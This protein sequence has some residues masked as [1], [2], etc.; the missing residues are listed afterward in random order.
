[1]G[2]FNLLVS[3]FGALVLFVPKK[4][5]GFKMCVDYRALNK[6]TSQNRCPLPHIDELLDRLGVAKFFTKIDLRSGYHQ[7]RVHPNDVPKIA[8][9]T[10]YG[11]FQ[12]SF[13]TFQLDKCSS[14][15]YAFNA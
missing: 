8:F 12:V 13:A 14:Y 15:I 10:R 1:M 5:G 11:H 9:R 6:A 4:D 2:I 3:L 7:I